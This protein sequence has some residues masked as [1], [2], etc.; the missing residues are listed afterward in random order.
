MKGPGLTGLLEG[1]C[2]W[3][4]YSGRG[5]TGTSQAVQLV[6]EEVTLKVVRSAEKLCR[7][8][9]HVTH[10]AQEI[11]GIQEVQGSQ[12]ETRIFLVT[13]VLVAVLV[14]VVLLVL[15]AL[16]RRM[17]SKLGQEENA[18]DGVRLV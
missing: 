12:E 5:F 1:P 9:R 7:R 14:V 10:L 4:L 2:S 11:K 18:E 17:W 16:V 13:S 8:P 15:L 6:R 3:R